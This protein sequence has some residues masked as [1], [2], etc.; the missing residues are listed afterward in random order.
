MEH[1][2]PR[3]R[4]W[5][6]LILCVMLFLVTPMQSILAVEANVRLGE[7]LRIKGDR[8]NQLLGTGL[9]VGLAGTGDGSRSQAV[10]Q[11]LSNVMRNY[12]I[13]LTPS[14]I[15][16]RNSAVVLVRC[17]PVFAKPGVLM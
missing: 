10:S 8:D 6:V 17:S 1:M 12:G 3:T 14:E 9:V 16:P 2:N 15:N 11:M 7:I 5:L 13:I 4:I